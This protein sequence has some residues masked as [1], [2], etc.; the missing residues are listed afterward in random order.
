MSLLQNAYVIY[1][2]NFIN[3]E[4]SNKY[5][6]I[7]NDSFD[8]KYNEYNNHKLNR[9][10][11]AFA[12]KKIIDDKKIIP[13][14]WGDDV[15][16]IEWTPELLEVKEKTEKKVKELTGIDWKY[17]IALG[18]CYTKKGDFIAFHSDNEELGSTQS[19]ASLS[20]GIPRTFNFMS[21]DMSEKASV[22]LENG[23]LI[24]M[25]DNCQENYR[26]GMRKENLSNLANED[27]LNK[28]NNTRINITFRVWNY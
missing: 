25:G 5:F 17:N 20:F 16:V 15:T 9:L 24:F 2:N 28:Y 23:S 7:F 22:V 6:K 4:E 10:T 19:I 8:W 27:T 1:E 13:P 11:C 14:I 18:N 3:E 12:D 21:K 26:H